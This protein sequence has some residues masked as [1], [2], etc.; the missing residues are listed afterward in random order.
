MERSITLNVRYDMPEGDWEK[1]GNVYRQLDGWLDDPMLPRWY[2]QETDAR[3]ICASVEPGGLQICGVVE[4]E[5]WT[6]WLTV[7]CAK[8]TFAP[9]REIY[10]AEM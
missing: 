2:G 7:L 10:D 5:L 8:L 4:P 6:A 9:G 3:Y 1:L